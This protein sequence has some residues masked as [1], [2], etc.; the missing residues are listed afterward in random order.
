MINNKTI[1]GFT[2]LEIM[3]A[4]VIASLAMAIVLPNIPSVLASVKLKSTSRDIVSTLRSARSQSI[5]KGASYSVI[6]N[7]D[8]KNYFVKDKEKLHEI[9]NILNIELLSADTERLSAE[10][11]GIRFFS[12]GSSTGGRITLSTD[13]KSLAVDINWLT[14]K[15]TILEVN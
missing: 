1:S 15:S 2:L 3:I 7:V 8:E 6:F 5:I 12:D 4:L 10:Q 9:P 14:G 13:K 11:S